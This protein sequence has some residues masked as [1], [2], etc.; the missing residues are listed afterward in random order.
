MEIDLLKKM[1]RR[2]KITYRAEKEVFDSGGL[3]YEGNPKTENEI[4]INAFPRLSHEIVSFIFEK[5][6]GKLK[7]IE[8]CG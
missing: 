6:S 1:L 7:H 4:C 5:E 2:A 8:V 3:L